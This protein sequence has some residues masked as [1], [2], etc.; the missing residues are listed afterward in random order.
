MAIQSAIAQ[1]GFAK[2]SAKGT[3]AANP[4]FAHGI[5]D[6]SIMSLEISQDRD[7]RTSGVLSASDVN[8]TSVVPAFG[9]SMRAHSKSIGLYLLGALGSVSTTGT[10]TYTHTF[11]PS[12]TLNYFS[13]FGQMNATNYKV[14]DARVNT[15]AVNFDEQG[16]VTAQVD[17]MGTGVTMTGVTFTPTV[18]DLYASY[19]SSI[20]GTFQLSTSSG[21]PV[22][23]KIKSGSITINNNLE[24]IDVAGAIT[25]DDVINARRE[26]DVTFDIVPDDF[27]AWLGLVTGSG[28]GTSIQSTP[29]Y[30]SFNIVLQNGA[31]DTLTFNSTRVAFLADFP[32]ADAG[33]GAVTISLA[34]MALKPAASNEIT[35]TLIN[36]QATY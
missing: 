29:V 18:D 25:P 34:G 28:S 4:T 8:R 17:G 22:A 35:V 27:S 30:G 10:T 13:A 12:N 19:F 5:T 16:I 1:V 9:Y 32:S 21:T 20:S 31:T 15:L 2:Q 14:T 33:G 7:L 23:A 24:P 36:G 26:I 6:G 3:A 11:T